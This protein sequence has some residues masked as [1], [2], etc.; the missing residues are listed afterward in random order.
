MAIIRVPRERMVGAVGLSS[1]LVHEVGHQAAAL[2]GLV[3]AL[4]AYLASHR[5]TDPT[6]G[7]IWRTWEAAIS[8]IVAD[9]WSVGTLGISA[10]QGMLA[11]VSLPR[12]FVFRPPGTDP[13]PMP[14]LRVLLSCAMGQALYPHPQWA[15]LARTWE[16]LY[17][18]DQL[19]PERQQELKTLVA[20]IPAF[21]RLLLDFRPA[22]LAGRS[23]QES[24][25][26]RER[27]PDRLTELHRTWRHDIAVMAR[28]PPSLVFAVIGQARVAGRITPE[29]ESEL[30]GTLLEAWALRS[31]LST[32]EQLTFPR[33]SRGP[34]KKESP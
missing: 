34:R 23:L 12:F 21:V 32:T 10:T 1:S 25:P 14:F 6:Q 22:T 4:R 2:L 5:P 26:T 28:Q 24:F 33:A 19:P 13:H 31:T 9:L 30:I 8:E 29:V 3:E 7:S 11:V 20:G 27:S 17:P 18:T 15:V 16:A